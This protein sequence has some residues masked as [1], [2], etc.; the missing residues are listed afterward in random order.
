M[1]EEENLKEVNQQAKFRYWLFGHYHGNQKVTD[2]HILLWGQ[3][4]RVC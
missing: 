4:V 3:I 2:R 1:K